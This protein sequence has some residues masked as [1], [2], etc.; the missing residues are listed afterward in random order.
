MSWKKRGQKGWTGAKTAKELTKGRE[1]QYGESEI[2]QQL[3]EDFEGDEYRYTSGKR[4]KNE[5]ARVKYRLAYYEQ[6]L[7]VEELK[8]DRAREKGERYHDCGWFGLSYYSSSV[9]RCKKE[10]EELENKEEKNKSCDII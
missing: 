5:K 2:K 10:L 1:R 4:K 7:K 8:R 6:R 3:Q 9:D